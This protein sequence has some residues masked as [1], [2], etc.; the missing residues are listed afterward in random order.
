MFISHD[1]ILKDCVP[2]GLNEFFSHHREAHTVPAKDVILIRATIES[3]E[4]HAFHY[5]E[6]REE[7][8]YI[9]DGKIEQWVGEEKKI[10]SAGDVVYVPPGVVHASFNVGDDEAKLLAI[11]GNLSSSAELAVDVSEQEP[12]CSLRQQSS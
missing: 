8:L 10:L 7:F 12:W 1:D 6:D 5:H 3:G 4:G 2:M 11:F 9:L